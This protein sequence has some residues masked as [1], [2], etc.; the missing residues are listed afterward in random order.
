MAE[1][2]HKDIRLIARELRKNATKQEK[3]LWYDFLSNHNYRWCRQMPIKGFVVDFCCRRAR[4]V[5]ELDG[6]QHYT[7]R[8]KSYD[9]ERTDIIESQGYKIIR[10]SNYDVEKNFDGVCAEIEKALS[11]RRRN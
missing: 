10:F 8:E 1:T 4:L 11:D 6:S 5:V 2:K 7:E 9:K 3:H